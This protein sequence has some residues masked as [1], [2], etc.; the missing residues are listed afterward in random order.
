MCEAYWYLTG[1]FGWLCKYVTG[2]GL[3]EMEGKEKKMSSD[4]REPHTLGESMQGE[5]VGRINTGTQ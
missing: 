1:T 3:R 4:H 5:A 2:V